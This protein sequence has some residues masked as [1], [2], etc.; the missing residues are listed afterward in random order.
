M[1]FDRGRLSR[2][3]AGLQKLKLDS[4]WLRRGVVSAILLAAVAL[5][6][7]PQAIM[8][9]VQRFSAGWLVLALVISTLQIMLCAWRWQFTAGLIDVPLRFAYALR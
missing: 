7:E 5:W 9:E 6:V 8:A 2:L 3:Q 1:G 4:P